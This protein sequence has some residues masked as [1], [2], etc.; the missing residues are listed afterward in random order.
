MVCNFG[1]F[2]IF[3][4]DLTTFSTTWLTHTVYE[5][6]G[7]HRMIQWLV[8]FNWVRTRARAKVYIFY[9]VCQACCRKSGKVPSL[10]VDSNASHYSIANEIVVR[11]G[12][13]GTP[14]QAAEEGGDNKEEA[15]PQVAIRD[16][17]HVLTFPGRCD[18]GDNKGVGGA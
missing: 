13:C 1:Y 10:M 3:A 14:A 2:P 4:V 7:F 11:V 12:T 5:T 8:A 16:D 17:R 15:S 9:R 18:G 6:K